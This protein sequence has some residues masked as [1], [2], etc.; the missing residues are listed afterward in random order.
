M[1][2][3]EQ[4]SQI[5]RMAQDPAL[6]WSG[7]DPVLSFEAD[8]LFY[9]GEGDIERGWD[10]KSAKSPSGTT[11]ALQIDNQNVGAQTV[12]LFGF[13]GQD[14][15]DNDKPADLFIVAAGGYGSYLMLLQ[16]LKNNPFEIVGARFSSTE[17]QLNQL[18]YKWNQQ[19][20]WGKSDSNIISA[21]TFR[22]EKDFLSGIISL[23][24]RHIVD[25]TTFVEIPM[26]ASTVLDI[27]LFIGIRRVLSQKIERQPSPPILP[28]K[29][30]RI[31]IAGARS[32]IIKPIVRR[33]TGD[34]GI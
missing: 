24:I 27:T 28:G 29:A 34:M 1:D 3:L 18:T 26:L 20:P 15:Y 11:Y 14:Y 5:E 2:I 30:G 7:E 23:P 4:L 8:D 21:T 32:G 25:I 6:G 33:Q 19:D 13:D 17:L 31:S 12:K 22:T 9:P 16:Y 10:G